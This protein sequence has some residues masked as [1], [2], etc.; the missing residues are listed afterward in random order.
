MKRVELI[1]HLER[2][3]CEFLREEITTP[4]T[5]IER[6]EGLLPFPGIAK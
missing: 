1:R 2:N 5:S 4:S 3:G 6:R